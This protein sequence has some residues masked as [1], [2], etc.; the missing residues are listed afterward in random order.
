MNEA[1][2]IAFEKRSL[3]VAIE[4]LLPVKKIPN[5]IKRT[6]KYKQIAISVQ[7]V[8]IVEPLIIHRQKGVRGKYMLLDGHLRLMVLK[9]LD[10]RETL[11]LVAKDDEA[12]TY[13]KRISRLSSIQEHYMILEA[14]KSGVSQDRVAKV[15]GV[16][17]RS[18]RRKQKL[19]DGICPEA[20]EI[21]KDRH[22]PGGSINIMKQ[23]NPFRQMEI[24][25]LMV[26]ANN[27]SISYAR[28]L[29]M[30]TP[31]EQ[32]KEPGQKKLVG[33]LSEE[34][35]QKMENEYENLQRD[36]K[37]IQDDYGTNVV[38]LVVANGYVVRLL[39]DDHVVRFLGKYHSDLLEQMQQITNAIA[40]ESNIAH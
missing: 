4:N 2:F 31:N 9:D 13:N 12:F 21:L 38:R 34:Q 33:G 20:V 11:C 5:S 26:A 15:L 1:V 19:L 3:T 28:A 8:G 29:L 27:F 23:V 14:I 35:R 18:I 6:K 24:A 39:N 40:E 22:F 30:A 10:I 17:V 16:D 36:M 32:L 37:A 25:E 7:E